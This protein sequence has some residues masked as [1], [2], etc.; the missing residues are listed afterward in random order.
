MAVSAMFTLTGLVGMGQALTY[1]IVGTGVT[2]CYGD[3]A[4]I[5]CP[6]SPTDPFYGQA[7]GVTPSYRNN[8]D[9]TTTDIITGLMWVQSR[10]QKMSWDSAFI[11]AAN[12]TTGGHNDWRV[13]TIKELYS[14]INYNGKSG[15]TA[16]TCI[17]YLDTNYFQMRYGPGTSDSII[18]QRIIDA[19][20]WSG[21]QYTGLTMGADTTIFGVNFVDGRI[22]GYPKYKPGTNVP[23]DMYVRFVRS[24]VNYGI[25]RLTD[26]GDSTVTDSATGL[27]W[28]KYDAGSGMDW[29]SALA[30]AQTKNAQ[31]YIGHN[32]WRLPDAKELQSIVDYGRSPMATHSA[33]IDPV[34]SCS[35]ITDEAG[36]TDYPF[37]WS[38]TTHLENMFGVYVAFGKAMGW[39]H[40]P[41]TA[42]YYT[43]ADVHGAGAQRSDPK[44]GSVTH[45]LM[46]ADSLGGPC[47]GL[48]P[49]GDVVRIFDYV[50]LART[51]INTTGINEIKGSLPLNLYPNPVSGACTISFN[52]IHATVKVEIFNTLGS[53]VGELYKTNIRDFSIDMSGLPEGIYM[54]NI[55]FDHN[56]IIR[57]VIKL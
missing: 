27:M 43:A 29:Q 38:N 44:F 57:K 32:D 11:M 17:P 41:P 7:Q 28:Q 18:G 40:M 50:R 23:I 56:Q 22:K 14:L 8:G 4:A 16:A 53:K 52:D 19:Q 54:L 30:Y 26:N 12:C 36:D 48:G 5:T 31:S 34:F 45:F 33:A 15:H 47:Y 2:I 24:N 39:M 6:A 3:T 37:Y 10:G 13:P 1:P 51:A 20:D 55:S 42:T 21:T 9:G 46:G 35:T 25:N 49:Q